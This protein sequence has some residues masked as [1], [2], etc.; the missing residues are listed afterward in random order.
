MEEETENRSLIVRG[1]YDLT[2]PERSLIERGLLL[3]ESLGKKEYI[4]PILGAKFVL[5]PAGTFI[6]GSPEDEPGRHDGETLH[7]VTISK[8]FYMQTTEVTQ[9]QWKKVMGNNPSW[10]K[11]DD[12]LPV[13]QVGWNNIQEFIRKINNMDGTNKYRL[14]TEAQWEYACRA[15]STAR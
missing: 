9:G 6:M 13:E 10:F 4:C 14:P 8:P 5:T 12:N 11:G 7:T 3:A 15:G 2:V 1:R